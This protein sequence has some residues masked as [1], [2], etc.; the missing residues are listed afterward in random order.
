M[1][2]P[3]QRVVTIG[4]SR[5]DQGLAD[6]PN[7]WPELD[8][9]DIYGKA[10]AVRTRQHVNP[11]KATLQIPLEVADWA[12][13][14]ADPRL[15]LAIDVGCGSGRFLLSLARRLPGY[16]LLGLDIRG[17]LVRRGNEWAA[18]LRVDA[19]ARFEIAN[20]T[21]SLGALLA[22]YPGRLM[23]V[24]IQFPDP[25]FKNRHKKR[26]VVQPELVHAL[27]ANM[28]PGGLVFLQSD[29][30]EAATAMRDEFE[31]SGSH[32]FR[33]VAASEAEVAELVQACGEPPRA[34]LRWAEAGYLLSNPLGVRTEREVH[35]LQQ[36]GSVFRMLLARQ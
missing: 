30:E 15:P 7:P 34:R 24:T 27:A 25:H 20:A 22:T 6:A 12:A 21:V 14:F 4:G 5:L 3:R 11:L 19:R 35:V 18:L 23:L 36:G 8:L 29:V 33:P 1:A 2:A 9:Q 28:A 16:N 17:P 10:E 31:L 26:R 13:V 32:A